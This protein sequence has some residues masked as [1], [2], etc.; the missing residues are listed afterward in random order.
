MS[1]TPP[2]PSPNDAGYLAALPAFSPKA[3]LEAIED[4]AVFTEFARAE[5]FMQL[6]MMRELA[7]NPAMKV[8]DRLRYMEVLTKAARLP[9]G[10][11]EEGAVEQRPMIQIIFEDDAKHSVTARPTRAPLTVDG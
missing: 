11:F 2:S 7:K 10:D 4:P 1:Q 8:P 5:L 9:P 6:M 3:L